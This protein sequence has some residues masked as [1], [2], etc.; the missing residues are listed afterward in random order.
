MENSN[1]KVLIS[2]IMLIIAAII[3]GSGFVTQKIA[4]A[5]ME[6]FTFMTYR[7]GIGSACL[8][9]LI[10]FMEYMRRRKD[11]A[12]G[13][14]TTPYGKAYFKKLCIV[15]PLCSF[16]NVT[17]NV[18]VQI[19]LS[20]TNASKAGFLNSIYIIFIPILGYLIFKKKSGPQIFL[21]IALA[22]IGL[23][24]LC[25]DD[26][27]VFQFG[28]LIILSATVL[29]ALHILLVSKFVHEMVGVHFSC[30][31][32]IFAT[33]VCG[34]CAFIFEEPSVVQLEACL[35]SVLYSGIFCV[36]VCYALQVTAQKYT[37]PSVAGLLMS[38]E[39]VFSAIFGV[40]FLHE[41]FTGKELIGVAFIVAA[42]VIAQLPDGVVEKITR[43]RA[44]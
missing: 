22:V 2:N 9:V 38:L 13:T 16:A 36:G 8:L 18:M 14:E 39:A 26:E 34:A 11:R 43:R 40:I 1:N 27:L 32:F 15:A 31:E 42:I 30:A 24:N 10:G 3:W 7:Y 29:F 35:W 37:D 17:G 28:D 21:G 4:A 19:G 25:F 23:Y 44:A 20:Y 41:T 5:E 12:L 6:A 33:F